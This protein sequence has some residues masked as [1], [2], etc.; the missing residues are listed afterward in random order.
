MTLVTLSSST[1][2]ADM[3]NGGGTFKLGSTQFTYSIPGATSVW[4]AYSAGDEPFSSYSTL[5]ASQGANFVAAIGLWDALIAPDFTKVND[6]ASGSG[7]LRVAFTSMDQGTAGYAYSGTPTAPGGKVGDIWLNSTDTGDTYASGT[8]GFTTLLHEIG[9]TLGL[10]HSFE[11][12]ALPAEYDNTRFTVMAYDSPSDSLITSFSPTATGISSSR[13]YIVDVTPMVIDIA[14]VQAIYGAE[15]T[16]RAGDDVYAYNND[17]GSVLRAIY[18]AGGNDTIDM[19]ACTRDCAIDLRPGAYSSIAEWSSADQIAYWT[20]LYPWA[21]SFISGQFDAHSYEWHDNLGIAQNTTIENANGGSADDI[22]LGN[23]VGNVLSGNAGNDTITGGAGNDTLNGNDGND[24]LDGG[25]GADVLV[26]GLGNDFYKIDNVG[27]T[28]SETS[29]AGGRDKVSSTIAYTLGANLDDL[30]LSGSAAINGT[31]NGLANTITGNAAANTLNGKG[32]ADTMSGGAGNDLYYVDNAG[33][34]VKESSATGGTDKVSSAVSYVLGANVEQLTL[35]GSANINGTGNTLD[36]MLSGNSGAN[37]LNGK[38]GV[39]TMYGG[40]GD[41]F[42]YVDNSGDRAIESSA[43]GGLDKVNSTVSFTLGA[44]VEQLILGGT[45]AINGTGNTLAN[46][47]SGNGA[48]NVLKG[49]GGVDILK[50]GAG[51]DTLQGGT[52]KDTLTGGTGNDKFLFAAGETS[53]NHSLSDRITDFATG[54]KIDLH[55]IDADTTAASDQ[56]FHFIGTSAFTVG[57]EG[58]LRYTSGG[59]VTWIEG[60][61]NGDGAADFAIYLT[62]DHAMV[63]ADFVL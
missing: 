63:Q 47:L 2:V 53:A 24:T 21:A 49:L 22:I 9:H 55:L 58:A 59:G 16:T 54:D 15:T 60:D 48:V 38:S 17:S 37:V 34:I 13:D 12:P 29:A 31:G 14:A 35:S 50:G 57:D 46:T 7:E 42:Y 5:S 23:T 4:S 1:I 45:A 6:N 32:G 18:D 25:T 11:T 36:N 30:T 40:L 10:K 27:D 52:E 20:A 44:N 26:G 62:G 33:D 41:D 51:N 3:Q 19:A 43:S 56:A 39:D 28:V 8:Y 61:A